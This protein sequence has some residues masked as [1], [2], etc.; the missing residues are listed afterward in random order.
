MINV[1]K[2]VNSGG[3]EEGVIIV[4]GTFYDERKE[5]TEYCEITYYKN[6]EGSLENRKALVSKGSKI[7]LPKDIF[8]VFRL[9]ILCLS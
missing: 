3:E 9:R 1:Y 6:Y 5:T 8:S 4:G 7:T 2:G